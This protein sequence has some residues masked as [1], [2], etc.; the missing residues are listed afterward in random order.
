MATRT[1]RRKF[2]TRTRRQAFASG[3]MLLDRESSQSINLVGCFPVTDYWRTGFI[4]ELLRGTVCNRFLGGGTIGNVAFPYSHPVY[5]NVFPNYGNGVSAT[6]VRWDF[7]RP[8]YLDIPTGWHTVT[9]W[10]NYEGTGN[11]GFFS[12]WTGNWGYYKHDPTQTFRFR[13]PANDFLATTATGTANKWTHLAYLYNTTTGANQIWIDGVLDRNAT[14]TAGSNQQTSCYVNTANGGSN[15][16][17]NNNGAVCDIRCYHGRL[18]GEQIR[19]L[20][21]NPEQLYLP[22]VRRTATLYLPEGGGPAPVTGSAAITTGAAT[23]A[24]SGGIVPLPNADLFKGFYHDDCFIHIA[25]LVAQQ[26]AGGPPKDSPQSAGPNRSGRWIDEDRW[27]QALICC[28]NPAAVGAAPSISIDDDPV[29]ASSEVWTLSPDIGSENVLTGQWRDSDND[30]VTPA[31]FK[32]FIDGVERTADGLFNAGASPFAST[33]QPWSFSSQLFR[34]ADDQLDFKVQITDDQGNIASAQR[35]LE[36]P[37]VD[38]LRTLTGHPRGR[39]SL[40]TFV[41]SP[42]AFQLDDGKWVGNSN[43]G[44]GGGLEVTGPVSIEFTASTAA[45]TTGEWNPQFRILIPD[46]GT[47]LRT[48]V[49]V[50]GDTGNPFDEWTESGPQTYTQLPNVDDTNIHLLSPMNLIDGDHV[51]IT[52]QTTAVGPAGNFP[53]WEFSDIRHI[54]VSG[55]PP[56]ETQFWSWSA[57]DITVSEWATYRGD[58]PTGSQSRPQGEHATKHTFDTVSTGQPYRVHAGQGDEVAEMLGNGSFRFRRDQVPRQDEHTTLIPSGGYDAWET[59]FYLKPNRDYRFEFGLTLEDPPDLDTYWR[60]NSFKIVFQLHPGGF[61]GSWVGPTNPPIAV[62]MFNGMW[63][64]RVR[65]SNQA[66]PTNVTHGT[67]DRWPIA[68]GT[69][70]FRIETRF[71]YTGAT[72]YCNLWMNGQQR[73]AR[74]GPVGINHSAATT[75]NSMFPSWGLYTFLDGGITQSDYFRITEVL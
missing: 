47:K 5:G 53:W 70:D 15:P 25:G 46:G 4:T 14:D 63:E 27:W 35:K 56:T 55:P 54:T 62:Q 42:P 10:V 61:G 51:K 21:Y 58:L 57:G 23:A 30:L 32:V 11:A 44:W 34:L 49:V 38:P 71:D 1:I 16:G 3:E 45:G 19:D 39:S 33:Q 72:G 52:F 36:Y 17:Y 75:P 8:A 9:M 37:Y 22:K 6:S 29:T 64:L 20:V 13:S 41:G 60:S 31:T 68:I 12:L 24:G 59:A 2:D 66:V 28:Q 18:Y 50:N 7:T 69:H 40:W 67:T 73:A 43:T 26:I 74:S 48:T 65:G